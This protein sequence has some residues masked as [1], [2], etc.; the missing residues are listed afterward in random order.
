MLSDCCRVG[1]ALS[2]EPSM[3]THNIIQYGEP[4]KF[5]IILSSLSLVSRRPVKVLG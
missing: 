1:V 2:G 3:N 5:R 4:Q